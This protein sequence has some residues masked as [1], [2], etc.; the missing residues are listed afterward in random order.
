MVSVVSDCAAQVKYQL[1]IVKKAFTFCQIYVTFKSWT[2]ND[3]LLHWKRESE[4]KSFKEASTF[5]EC[6]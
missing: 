5:E 4:M 3:I 1:I 6:N 2:E